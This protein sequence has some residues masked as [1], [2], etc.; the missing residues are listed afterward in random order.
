MSCSDTAW[1]TGLSVSELTLRDVAADSRNVYKELVRPSWPAGAEPGMVPFLLCQY[2]ESA[3][4]NGDLKIACVGLTVVLAV[5]PIFKVL[6]NVFNAFEAQ[7]DAADASERLLQAPKIKGKPGPAQIA[8]SDA[9]SW[10]GDTVTKG[11]IELGY[12]EMSLIADCADQ[13]AGRL[14][15]SFSADGAYQATR[16]KEEAKLEISDV[17]IYSLVPEH[18]DETLNIL[19]KTPMVWAMVRAYGETGVAAHWNSVIRSVDLV[20]TYQDTK[21]IYKLVKMVLDEAKK[22]GFDRST[23]YSYFSSLMERDDD[24]ALDAAVATGQLLAPNAVD[25]VT[26][27]EVRIDVLSLCMINDCMGWTVPFATLT[28]KNS[29]LDFQVRPD[30]SATLKT[31]TTVDVSFYNVMNTCFEP[32]VE[33]WTVRLHAIE[34]PGRAT[35]SITI[36]ADSRLEVNVSEMHMR[37]LVQTVEGWLQ[38]S[39]TWNKDR[40]VTQDKFSPYRLRNE[41]GVPLTFWLGSSFEPPTDQTLT[42]DLASGGEEPFEFSQRRALQVRQRDMSIEFHTLSIK[43]EGID[44]VLTHVPV[45]IIG[46]HMLP[47]GELRAVAEIHNDSGCKIIAI[48]STFK[49]YNKTSMS[50]DACISQTEGGGKAWEQQLAW[51]ETFAGECHG[52]V[53]LNMS[54][55]PYMSVRP[56]GGKFSYSSPFPIPTVPVTGDSIFVCCMPEEGSDETQP[57]Y[58]RVRLDAKK[59]VGGHEEN[60]RIVISIH[61]AL[62]VQN[63]LPFPVQAAMYAVPT[64]QAGVKVA[65]CNISEGA[66]EQLFCADITTSLRMTAFVNG[67]T[68]VTKPVLVHDADGGALDKTMDLIDSEGGI[69]R[70]GMETTSS[71]WGDLTIVVYAQYIIRNFTQ[72]PLVYGASGRVNK[73]AAGQ[74]SRLAIAASPEKSAPPSPTKGS[75][76]DRHA[77]SVFQ[78]IYA[79]FGPRSAFHGTAVM[80]DPPLADGDIINADRLRGNVALVRRGVIPFTEKARKVSKAGAIGVIFINT[81]DTTFLAE[82]DKGPGIRLPSVMLTKTEGEMLARSAQMSALKVHVT[83]E[84]AS[85]T[86]RATSQLLEW[87]RVVKAAVRVEDAGVLGGTPDKAAGGGGVAEVLWGTEEENAGDVD[88]GNKEITFPE[89]WMEM[90]GDVPFMFSYEAED[91]TGNKAAFCLPG[92]EWSPA[93]SLESM[94]TTGVLAVP[95]RPSELPVL[96]QAKPLF[97]FGLS[98]ELGTGNYSRSKVCSILPRYTVCNRLGFTLQLV[99]AGLEEEPNAVVELSDNDV[100]AF[101]WIDSARVKQ[102]RARVVP[103]IGTHETFTTSW[104]GLIDPE[105]VGNFSI[106]FPPDGQGGSSLN[107]FIEIRQRRAATFIVFRQEKPEKSQYAVVNRSARD[108]EAWQL[109]AGKDGAEPTRYK[110]AAG[111]RHPLAWDRPMQDRVLVV[112]V[113]GGRELAQVKMEEFGEHKLPGELHAEVFAD[114]HARALRVSD[115]A[116]ARSTTTGLSSRSGGTD[117]DLEA[118]YSLQV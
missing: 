85:R 115:T 6:T 111:E 97:E 100:Q 24:P 16:N 99:Q 20:V 42:K 104:S 28:A 54:S 50:V 40:D 22:S 10:W 18:K 108:I 11:T 113:A 118:R 77:D 13:D 70:L 74:A 36:S 4:G 33:P 79:V 67:F 101:H 66:T 1:N 68:K 38:D 95:G 57:T 35:A 87:K 64:G 106:R 105:Q 7:D 96:K 82:G 91:L 93:F 76:D 44:D 27:V 3:G 55:I 117:E 62:R 12:Y 15:L 25:S 26:K 109:K 47:L 90:P 14:T 30:E 49:V 45:D 41:S 78:A 56:N 107:V 19:E 80:C 29:V 65:E 21:R 98:F 83:P 92:G 39:K 31:G 89:S 84:S 51:Q 46:V 9:Y 69:L 17:T 52:C 71:A 114:G 94:G 73:A 48:Q 61:P 53:P 5:E 58:F 43:F 103:S 23:G 112:Q 37:S 75:G 72:L 81:D 34:T 110:I 102:C 60:M 86:Q 88:A 63:A 2:Q 59:P 116:T 32:L 8:A